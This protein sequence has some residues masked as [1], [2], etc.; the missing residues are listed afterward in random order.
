MN[1]VTPV[2]EGRL[3]ELIQGVNGIILKKE[4]T[5]GEY[6]ALVHVLACKMLS[7][8]TRAVEKAFIKNLQRDIRKLRLEKVKNNAN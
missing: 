1:S 7:E 5:V 6:F 4:A 8:N 3:N 2:Q